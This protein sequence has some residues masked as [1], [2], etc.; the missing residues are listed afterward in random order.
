LYDQTSLINRY[1][2]LVGKTPDPWD[3]FTKIIDLHTEFNLRPIFFFLVGEKGKV[4]KNI[5]LRN[6]AMQKIIKDIAHQDIEIGLHT[7]FGGVE[8]PE[9]WAQ[10]KDAL[11]QIIGKKINMSRQ[12]FIELKFPDSFLNFSKIG[13]KYD[14]SIIDKQA[15]AFRLGLTVPIK[16]FDLVANRTTDLTLIP[17]AIMDVSLKNYKKWSLQEAEPECDKIINYYR[18]YGGVFVTIWHNESLSEDGEWNNWNQ[19]YKY[20]LKKTT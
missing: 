3:C 11:E 18:K 7:S 16:F 10:E 5:P 4:D 1:K 9:K 17:S 12:H 19:I 20:I 13:L 8:K 14:F 6:P 2:T 15:L